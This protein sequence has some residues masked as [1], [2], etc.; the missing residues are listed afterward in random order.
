MRLIASTRQFS[1]TAIKNAETVPEGYRKIKTLQASFQVSAELLITLILAHVV[2][3][4]NTT[5]CQSTWREVP[6]T[7]FSSESPQFS[8]SLVSA[9]SVRSSTSCRTQRLQNKLLINLFSPLIVDALITEKN[10]WKRCIYLPHFQP[11]FHWTA[12]TEAINLYFLFSCQLQN[13]RN[14][15]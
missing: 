12:F 3:C 9:W 15:K 11:A 6:P 7:K 10:A 5:A 13:C 1:Q 4:R 8:A 2:L 14:K